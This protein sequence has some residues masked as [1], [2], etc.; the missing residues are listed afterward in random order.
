[1]DELTFQKDVEFEEDE[2]LWKKR[3][4][5]EHRRRKC[6]ICVTA[7]GSPVFR[8]TFWPGTRVQCLSG[9]RKIEIWKSMEG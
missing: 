4:F 1:M 7:I 8:R 5:E 3:H 9:L 6:S 2:L